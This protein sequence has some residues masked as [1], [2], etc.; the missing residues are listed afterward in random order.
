MSWCARDIGKEGTMAG[1]V[2][3]VHTFR[4]KMCN[5]SSR[6]VYINNFVKYLPMCVCPYN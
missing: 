6:P 4:D 3:M 1:C 5:E 2:E